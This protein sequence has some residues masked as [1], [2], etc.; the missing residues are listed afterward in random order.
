MGAVV[1]WLAAC[2]EG[3]MTE[4]AER[5]YENAGFMIWKGPSHSEPTVFL[6][7]PRVLV[8]P[9][10]PARLSTHPPRELFSVLLVYLMLMMADKVS[11]LCGMEA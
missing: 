8:G 6:N 5:P 3:T 10:A 7:R 1:G 9:S 2:V 4:R 11:S